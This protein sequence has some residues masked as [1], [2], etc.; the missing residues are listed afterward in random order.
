MSDQL[1]KDVIQ[2]DVK[3]WSK[4]VKYWEKNVDWSTVQ[5]GLE[6]GGREGGLSLWMALKGVKVVCSDLK[7]VESTAKPLHDTYAV[8]DLVS[9]EDIDA[10]AIPY[11]NHFDVI[12]F[13][14]IIG[15]IGR[16]DNFELQKK[17]FSEIH[18]ALKPGGKLL[19]AENLTASSIHKK[20]RKRYV[21]WANSWRYLSP[22]ELTECLSP[23][24]S[25]ELKATGVMGT[26][27]RSE[28]QRSFLSTVDQTVLNHITPKSWK[29]IGYGI[30]QK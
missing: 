19:F 26:F 13:K 25:Y 9:Y 28:G 21:N 29:Y 1:L 8:L 22:N 14:S 17:V 24:S 11:E 7:E 5:H 18:K 10:S 3:S 6:L 2:W 27:G 15:G 16:N 23:F 30:A 4:A 20:M 12:V